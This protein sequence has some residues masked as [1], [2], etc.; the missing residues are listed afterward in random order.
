MKNAYTPSILVDQLFNDIANPGGPIVVSDFDGTA[1]VGFE[2]GK[3][4]T[5]TGNLTLTKERIPAPPEVTIEDLFDPAKRDDNGYFHFDE[6]R[7]VTKEALFARNN[8]MNVYARPE[9][10]KAITAAVEA[11]HPELFIIN[12]GRTYEALAAMMLQSGITQKTLDQMITVTNHGSELRLGEGEKPISLAPEMDFSDKFFLRNTALNE[13][14]HTKLKVKI[15]ET[16][17]DLGLDPN[18]AK[19]LII[20]AKYAKDEDVSSIDF[21]YRALVDAAALSNSSIRKDTIEDAVKKVLKEHLGKRVDGIEK[22]RANA[23]IKRSPFEAGEE[24]MV[25]EVRPEGLNKGLGMEALMRELDK[26][27][28]LPKGREVIF[29]GDSMLK[30]GVQNKEGN[31]I[32]QEENWRARTDYPATVFLKSD[33]DIISGTQP[34]AKPEH[35]VTPDMETAK[36]M[37][38][39]GRTVY[40]RHPEETPE[41]NLHEPKA[42]TK[43]AT[44]TGYPADYDKNMLPD[45]TMKTPVQYSKQVSTAILNRVKNLGIN[46]QIGGLGGQTL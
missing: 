28:L 6:G 15:G 35:K 46:M 25:I 17:S 26:R 31:I 16:L 9:L 43:P 20:N 40:V 1:G 34:Y 7:V 30:N 27:G 45:L 13:E 11:G 5:K 39:K 19:E 3:L 44:G 14:L 24:S 38:I 29:A 32:D 23:T 4:D 37:G 18:L 12:T 22:S 42:I 10:V 41:L 8:D 21:H 33:E 2:V 36:S